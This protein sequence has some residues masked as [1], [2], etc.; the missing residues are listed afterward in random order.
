MRMRLIPVLFVALALSAC[1]GSDNGSNDSIEIVQ[2]EPQTTVCLTA[3][4]LAAYLVKERLAMSVAGAMPQLFGEA[5]A[6]FAMHRNAD[7][8]YELHAFTTDMTKAGEALRMGVDRVVPVRYSLTRLDEAQQKI[9]VAATGLQAWGPILHGV[10]IRIQKNKVELDILIGREDAGRDIA[11]AAK[12][13][14]DMVFI[15][16]SV[17]APIPAMESQ[18]AAVPLPVMD[19]TDCAM[20]L[21]G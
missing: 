20:I 18:P 3:A 14:Y 8:S 10:G 21:N 2:K 6:G 9:H 17:S 5:Y 7:N 13:P 12:V 11:D 16:G 4:Q 1:G 15:V 19:T